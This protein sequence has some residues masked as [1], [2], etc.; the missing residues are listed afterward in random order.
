MNMD[1]NLSAMMTHLA[2][3]AIPS[4]TA[5][6]YNKVEAIIK[7]KATEQTVN[8]LRQIIN[9]LIK[10][11]N[12]LVGIAQAY[13]Q[14]L[15]AQQI[16][17]DN[18]Q[19]IIDSVL[20]VLK[21]FVEKMPDDNDEKAAR[22]EQA[23]EALDIIEQLLSVDMLTVLQVL[24]FNYKKAIGEPLTIV[25]QKLITSISRPDPQLAAENNRLNLQTSLALAT[26]AQDEEAAERLKR[27][28]TVWRATN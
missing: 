13:E 8:E 10:E 14:E 20:P 3:L 24:G 26:I 4:A 17:D 18:I 28:L 7:G 22:K 15:V 1:P 6:I 21:V 2:E 23:E 9:D 5:T 27:V 12:D 11:R 19:Y 16:S 25:L